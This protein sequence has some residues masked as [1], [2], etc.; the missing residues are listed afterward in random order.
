METLII[1][2]V[3]ISRLCPAAGYTVSYE[4]VDGGQGGLMM[5]ASESVDELGQKEII[6]F[7]LLPLTEEQAKQVLDLVIPQPLHQVQYISPKDGTT[8]HTMRRTISQA[9]YRGR[10]G[11][12]NQYW[13]GIVLTFKEK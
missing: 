12:G 1:D 10:G 4:F 5:D 13:T 2:G 11:T 3:D 8:Q 6:T 7:P 9:Q